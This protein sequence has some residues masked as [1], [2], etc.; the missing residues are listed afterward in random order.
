MNFFDYKTYFGLAKKIIN[1]KTIILLVVI[2]ITYTIGNRNAQ[3][4][5]QIKTSVAQKKSLI[6]TVS[7]S[8][9]ARSQN[10]ADI[11]FAAGGRL[12]YI[13]VKQ[14]DHVKK[15]QTIASLDTQDLQK[16]LKQD[17]NLYLN[18]RLTFEDTKDSQ[19]DQ[20]ITD[21]LKRIAQRAQDNLDNTVTD[22]E[23]RDLAI[24]FSSIYSP[25]NGEIINNP[26]FFAGSNVSIADTIATVADLSKLEFVAQVDETE[27]GKV[28]AGQ[29]ATITLDAFPDEKIDA[30]VERIAPASVTTST[31]STAFEVVFTLPESNKFKIG[32]N[33]TADVQIQRV[34]ISLVI[35][36]EAVQDNNTVY[37]R[38]GKDYQ[39]ITVEK[40]IESDTEVEITKGL[41]EN[42]KIVTAGFDQLTKDS[43]IQKILKKL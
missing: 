29:E 25:I 12:A 31:G 28:T 3:D 4:A 30:T 42:D 15:Y 14:G 17:L 10:Q 5:S 33:G 40:G 11:K 36:Q 16:K 18:Q 34:D 38:S 23:L 7:A 9:I 26:K 13:N 21:S 41:N 1:R 37:V 20:V 8:G 32:M 22:V 43:L 24:K 6:S 27:I 35:P 19:K 39:K 2:F